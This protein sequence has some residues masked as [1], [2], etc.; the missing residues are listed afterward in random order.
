M[1]TLIAKLD[2]A[3]YPSYA[4]NWDDQ[5]F[6]ER[7][8]QRL[9]RTS[10]ILDLG[11]GAGIVQQMN[12]RG[13]AARVCGVDLDPRVVDNPMLDEG[14]IADAGGI[15]YP[16]ATFDIVFAD[17]VLEHLPDPLAVFREIARGPQ[18]GRHFP[19]QNP[20]QN[21]LHAHHRPAHPAP[22]PSIRQPH[23]RSGRS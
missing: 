10:I 12:F 9:T 11:A 22:L 23:S 4:R 15:P 18:T 16:D 3:L 7:I 20:Q 19:V 2:Q 13:L 6:R 14:K 17:N 5:L 8:L 1:T 21:A